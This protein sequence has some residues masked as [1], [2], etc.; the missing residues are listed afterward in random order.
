M[1]IAMVVTGGFDESG[2]ERV[3]PSLLWLVERLATRHDVVV[4]VL[5]YHDAP[6]RYRL[7]GATIHDLGR[8]R[9]LFN[10]C[11]AVAAAMAADGPFD[12]VHGYWAVPAGVV[13]AVVGRRLGVP[14][15]VT[16]DSGEFVSCPDIGY[17]LQSH[18]RGRITVAAATR[19]ATRVTV[20]STYQHTLARA[21]G[22]DAVI[23]PLGVD[24]HVFCA[25][26]E[27][28]DGPPF[29][30]LHVASLN[31][32]KDHATL[33]RAV[34]TLISRGL[35]LHVDIVGEDTVAGRV[36]DLASTLGI[37]DRVTLHGF[38][39]SPDLV[40]L[41]HRAHLFVLSSRHEAAGVVL[42]EAA[43]CGV[44]VVGSAVGYLADWSP[45]A[46][47]SVAPRDPRALAD[48]IEGLLR[49]R[50][51]RGRQASLAAAW[52]RAH[53]ADCTAR[54]FEQLFHDVLAPPTHATRAAS[55]GTH[56]T[57]GS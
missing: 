7:L 28:P 21:H 49:D 5:R 55:R 13:A 48:A 46:A 16:C 6:R 17:G 23:I 35:D 37:E 40:P 50:D 42:L 36:T 12:V 45:H 2:H 41:Y 33:L 54:A 26:P 38:R 44:P 22:V 3:I 51:R 29:H 4:Y 20:C 18:W 24:T 27:L 43:A 39:S 8:P 19:L 11:R 25:G 31:P 9:G 52:A 30:V 56:R 34:Q 32:V 53:D 15:I 14:S 1:R 47:T 57:P 10:Q